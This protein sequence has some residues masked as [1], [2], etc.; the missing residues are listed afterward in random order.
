MNKMTMLVGLLVAIMSVSA[1]GA[2]FLGTPTAELEQGQWNV[3]FN[4][5]YIDM[6]LDKAK[7]TWS[8]QDYDDTGT[9]VDSETGSE[10]LEFDDVK[11]QRYYG[12]IGYGLTDSW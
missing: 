2:G 8:E 12:T 7:V 5:T 1:F 10:K 3:G 9:L 11:T 6:E 4:Y